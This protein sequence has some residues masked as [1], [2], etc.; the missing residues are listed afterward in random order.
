M[1]AGENRQVSRQV[2]SNAR[3]K[4]VRLQHANGVLIG[5]PG[6]DTRGR[7]G[8]PSKGWPKVSRKSTIGPL[9]SHDSLGG[10]D[11]LWAGSCHFLSRSWKWD[12]SLRKWKITL[13][14]IR[15]FILSC[16]RWYSEELWWQKVAQFEAQTLF[17]SRFY[18]ATLQGIS[19]PLRPSSLSVLTHVHYEWGLGSKVRDFFTPSPTFCNAES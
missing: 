3:G 15:I 9:R 13:I 1:P 6:P 4:W 18:A 7:Q 17:S 11:V 12:S 5:A 2:Q 14:I 16:L 8:Q 19:I 10:L